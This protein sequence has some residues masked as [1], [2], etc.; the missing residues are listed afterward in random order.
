MFKTF[1]IIFMINGLIIINIILYLLSY[2][3]ECF[4]T[5]IFD[6]LTRMPADYSL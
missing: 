4:L 3:K 2:K 5:N 1:R 6:I